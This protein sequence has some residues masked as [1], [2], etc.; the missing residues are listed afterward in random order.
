M[1]IERKQKENGYNH[2]LA[3]GCSSTNYTF[4]CLPDINHSFAT[5]PFLCECF[6]KVVSDVFDED[7]ELPDLEMGDIIV[8]RQM[9]AYTIASATE[10]SFYPKLPIVVVEDII[11]YS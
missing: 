11:D 6:Y 8:A 4:V 5:I 3:R 10:F 2:T 7:I 1:N 9:G